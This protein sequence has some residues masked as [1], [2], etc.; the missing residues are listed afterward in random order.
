MQQLSE[1]SRDSISEDFVVFTSGIPVAG[2]PVGCA[3]IVLHDSP[4]LTGWPLSNFVYLEQVADIR[5]TRVYQP[6]QGFPTP[7]SAR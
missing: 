7:S 2:G 5:Y 3:N 1:V 6:E 4:P